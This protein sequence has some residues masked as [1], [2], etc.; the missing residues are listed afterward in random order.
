MTDTHTTKCET[1]W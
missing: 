1:S